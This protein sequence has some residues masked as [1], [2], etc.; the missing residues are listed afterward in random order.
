MRFFWVI[1]EN[2]SWAA[3]ERAA[4][5]LV[6]AIR[7]FHFQ[8][9]PWTRFEGGAKEPSREIQARISGQHKS[10]HKIS[11]RAPTHLKSIWNLRISILWSNPEYHYIISVQINYGIFFEFKFNSTSR[12]AFSQSKEINFSAEG[13]HLPNLFLSIKASFLQT[14][15]LF[16]FDCF[17]LTGPSSKS[18]PLT[19][20]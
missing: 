10:A 15:S 19:I 20:L 5:I 17:Y 3:S 8:R 4:R 16:R 14:V 9:A 2:G 1:Q 18:A 12:A 11:S 13:M 7:K 6:G